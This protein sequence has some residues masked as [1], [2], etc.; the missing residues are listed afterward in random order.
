[1]LYGDIYLIMEY[2]QENGNIISISNVFMIAPAQK[3]TNN[4]KT[5]P[6][7]IFSFSKPIFKNVGMQA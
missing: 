7:K 4:K 5:T 2:V 3:Q 1:M 6:I